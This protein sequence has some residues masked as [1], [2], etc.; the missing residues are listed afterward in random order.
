MK[1]IVLL[2]VL[3]VCASSMAMNPANSEHQSNSKRQSASLNFD[4]RKAIEK[5]NVASARYY[6][7]QTRRDL[8]ARSGRHERTGL[9]QAVLM[10]WD[11]MVKSLLENGA[12]T[13]IPDKFGKTALHYA[14]ILQD[15]FIVHLLVEHIKN[16]CKHSYLVGFSGVALCMKDTDG[17]TPCDYAFEGSC[18]RIV[19][20][21]QELEQVLMFPAY[22]SYD[23]HALPRDRYGGA[24][25]LP[26]S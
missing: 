20:R 10:H 19:G 2:S 18:E 9:H 17:K 16:S 14:V 1:Q 22:Q 24:W 8:D 13:N 23:E 12:A 26:A 5:G 3:V 25:L 11:E 7:Y 4:L 15:E 21:L 6:V